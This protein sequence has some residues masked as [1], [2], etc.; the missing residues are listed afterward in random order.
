M[1]YKI[2]WGG[3]IMV[4]RG[5]ASREG[6]FAVAAVKLSAPLFAIAVL[7]TACVAT[8]GHTDPQGA[9]STAKLAS[10]LKDLFTQWL[11]S[12]DSTEYDTRVLREATETGFITQAQYQEAL[13]LYTDCMS[14]AGYELQQ[15]RY[16]TGVVN[17]QPPPVVED[18]DALMASDRF[19]REKTSVYVV[20][21]FETQQG[22]P[23]LYADAA[24]IAYTCLKDNSL[25]ASDVTVEQVSVFLTDSLQN[26]YPFDVHDLGVKSCFY[27]AGMVYD[28]DGPK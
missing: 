23:N 28:I 9:T 19:C 18:V 8:T 2:I 4:D 27:A 24:T 13:D 25:I 22:N 1:S 21:G 15:T 17:L 7:A 14:E 5:R 16:P 11:T 3:A 6:H 10:S 20:A 12:P 26:Q